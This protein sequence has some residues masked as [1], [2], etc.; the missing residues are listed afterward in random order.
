MAHP[1]PIKVVLLAGGKSL[2][3]GSPKALVLT[4]GVPL[5]VDRYRMLQSLD[6]E[7][8]VLAG[9]LTAAISELLP[10]ARVIG[11][12]QEGPVVAL[13]HLNSTGLHLVVAVDMPR[14]ES[15]DLQAFIAAAQG[16]A[17][18]GEAP[19]TL[20]CLLQFPL[21]P[22]AGRSLKAQ[23]LRQDAV[24]LQPAGC[25]PDHL[26]QFNTMEAWRDLHC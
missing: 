2:R 5:V 25:P 21:D 24:H 4:G 14:L 9:E 11:D 7:P 13:R 17:V 23:L 8:T 3:F 12:V 1:I 19:A 18:L 10:E 15:A 6:P 26:V 16:P 20:P 22:S